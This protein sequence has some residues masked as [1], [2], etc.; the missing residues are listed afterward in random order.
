MDDSYSTE[1]ERVRKRRIKGSRLKETNTSK[2]KAR[3]KDA[4]R[5]LQKIED[6]GNKQKHSN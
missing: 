1:K 3:Q 6:S 5:H 4:R 2:G